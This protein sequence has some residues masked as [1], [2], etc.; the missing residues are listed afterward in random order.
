[1]RIISLLDAFLAWGLNFVVA[2]SP[3]SPKFFRIKIS[4]LFIGFMC[5]LTFGQVPAPSGDYLRMRAVMVSMRDGARMATDIY[6]PAA[7]GKVE[8]GTFPT[9]LKITPFNRESEPSQIQA[10]H[11]VSLG[12][13]VVLQ[14]MRSRYGSD[15]TWTQHMAYGKDGYDTV[16]WIA[17][18]PWSNGK[19]GTYGVSFE[20]LT[21]H[22]LAV[23]NPPHLT[24]MI[25]TFCHL[26]WGSSGGMRYMGAFSV[27]QLMAYFTFLTTT[28][29]QALRNPA[30]REATG[31]S[32][33]KLFSYLD[34]LPLVKGTTP[35][36]LVPDYE[37]TILEL[38]S[39]SDNDDYW[40]EGEYHMSEMD[41][42]TYSDVPVLNI[43]GW[44]DAWSLQQLEAYSKL[45]KLNKT[46][47][48][49]I[50][51][52]WIHSRSDTASAGEVNFGPD[53]NIGGLLRALGE[54]VSNVPTPSESIA[55]SRSDSVL[56]GM[57]GRLRWGSPLYF[58]WFDRWLR[59]S[60]NQI[61]D[62][63]PVWIFVMGGGDGLKD[64]AGRLKHGGRWRG[65][66]EWPVTGTRYT[67]YYL[68]AGGNLRPEKA[69]S[70]NPTSYRFD[71]SNPIP[72]IGGTIW[73]WPRGPGHD[74]LARP[75]NGPMDQRCRT[76]IYPCQ[77]ELALASRPDN[78]VF[79]TEPLQQ[80]MEV[81]G[82][83]VVKLWISSSASDTDFT[84]KLIDVYP[85]SPDFPE[86]F[87]M[88]LSEGIQRA[89]YRNSLKQAELMEQ[90]RVYPLE[91]VLYPTSNL[92]KTGH[93]IRVDIS[94]SN[95]PRFDI[96][97]N[98][99]GP[100]GKD[101]TKTAA[102]NS[103]YHEPERASHIL[104]PIIPGED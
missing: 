15:G 5:G 69:A 58:L 40:T 39:H 67:P 104:L 19:I 73:I 41:F 12:F 49:L 88:N 43:A 30:I 26:A 32:A 42:Q 33:F 3:S 102:I 16:E 47:Q 34:N 13:A 53:S 45:R 54:D 101:L 55:V 61:L 52:P 94:S 68:H 57:E 87:A 4:C 100:L 70:S 93:R 14:D 92:F 51:G 80:D 2:S 89:R 10:Q 23:Q 48:R 21:Q 91:V 76:Q 95:F 24:A 99:G 29:K 65:E 82:P 36:T 59:D 7:G 71:P 18:Q 90:E 74:P 31:K 27:P 98:T 86:G 56:H 11:W 17:R 63:P 6:L 81:T 77:D 84:A 62:D 22:T 50:V 8:Q 97:P 78:L 96:N 20:A 28:S 64:S 1:M 9:I 83:I 79:Q 66:K 44:Y 75:P 85:P 37:D 25:P 35:L 103:I 60:P 72:T 38:Q 46:G